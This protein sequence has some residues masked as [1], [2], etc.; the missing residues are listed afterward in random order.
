M[1]LKIIIIIVHGIAVIGRVVDV[2]IVVVFECYVAGTVHNGNSVVAGEVEVLL[3]TICE[4]LV[5][6]IED[7]VVFGLIIHGRIINLL[8]L[9]TGVS[10]PAS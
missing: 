10:R 3:R 8:V 6:V 4:I 2:G 7:G 5:V 9:V 1:I